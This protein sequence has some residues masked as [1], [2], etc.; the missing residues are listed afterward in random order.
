[1]GKLWREFKAFAMGGNALDLALGFIIGA[2]FSTLVD[3]L[4]KDVIMQSVAALFGQPNFSRLNVNIPH[5]HRPPTTINVGNFAS[6]LVNFLLLALVLFFI[7]KGITLLGV[8]RGRVFEEREC[9]YCLEKVPSR[10]LICKTCT[11]PLVAEL[12]SLA[13]AERRAAELRARRLALS[14]PVP[15]LRRSSN[16]AKPP[17]QPDRSAEPPLVAD[18]IEPTEPPGRSG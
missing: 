14:L 16:A 18:P 9:P 3:S 17:A 7:V 6:A 5:E 1:M 10:A 11:Q 8:G 13:E 12:P 15:A 4:S 2:A